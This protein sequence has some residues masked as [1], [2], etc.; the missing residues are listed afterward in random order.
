[1]ARIQKGQV[2]LSHGAFYVRFYRQGKRIAHR[3]CQKDQT[4]YSPDC[5]P[6]RLLAQE[7]MLKE[8]S[9]KGPEPDDPGKAKVTEFWTGV[10]LPWCEDNLKPSSVHGYKKLW[11]G[12]LESFFEGRDFG[13]FKPFHGSAFLSSL[14]PRMGR[15]SLSHVRQLA[16]SIFAQ[17]VARGIIDRNPWREV[18]LL[19][20]PKETRPTGFYTVAE[21][22]EAL[23]LLSVDPRAQVAFGLSFL[24]ALRPGE[25]A[26]LRWEDF[27]EDS[28]TVRRSA[29]RGVVGTTKTGT[30]FEVPL[31]APARI[32]A[33]AWRKASGSPTEGWLFPNPS[34]TRPL[35]MSSFANKSIRR[36]LGARYKGLYSARRGMATA[37]VGLTGNVVSAQG[38]LRH[39]NMASTLAFY[40]K[41]TPEETERGMRLLADRWDEKKKKEEGEGEKK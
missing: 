23:A 36:L 38:M 28:V 40:K 27:S 29:W 21:A 13:S 14:A 10:F 20:R 12:T 26:A 34:G 8:N 19:A 30:S 35:D 24:L 6:V 37:L 25:L 1:M 33:E 18:R 4:H 22:K 15:N 17:A 31:V 7:F 41:E 32:L 5:K 39:A 11:S 16:S 3:L 9:R 2:V